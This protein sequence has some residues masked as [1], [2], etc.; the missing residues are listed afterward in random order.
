MQRS[1]EKRNSADVYHRVLSLSVGVLIGGIAL[2]FVG[3][4]FVFACLY[5]VQDAP[6]ANA[7]PGRFSDLFFFSV[8]TMAAIGYGAMYPQTLYANVIAT[9]EGFVGL[10]GL[11]ICSG[12]A[13]ARFSRPTA[14]VRFSTVA[15]ICKYHGVP[16]LMFRIGNQ[17]HSS[18]LDAKVQVVLVRDDLSPEG[19][20][21]RRFHSL[22]LVRAES[23]F[24][25]LTWT[26]MHQID[27]SSPLFGWS[28]SQLKE[29]RGELIATL[30]GLDETLVQQTH[31]RFSYIADEIISDHKFLDMFSHDAN[32]KTTI[33]YSRF[34]QTEPATQSLLS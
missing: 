24:L 12:L 19:L 34:N 29:A 20:K 3:L 17:R 18:I 22:N 7:R 23:P 25:A 16:T 14:Q 11:A 21:M 26:V 15:V 10:L 1:G 6:V 33:D 32:G 8:Q 13:F 9:I 4:N 28:C 2:L 5:L 27:D 31:S 30:T